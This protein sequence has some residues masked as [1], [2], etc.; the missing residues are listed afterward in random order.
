MGELSLCQE[1]IEGV[2][3]TVSP[4]ETDLTIIA[5]LSQPPI[6]AIG[7]TEKDG[8]TED[9]SDEVEEEIQDSLTQLLPEDEMGE[10]NPLQTPAALAPLTST[11]KI[12]TVYGDQIHQSD[13]T[14]LNG[15]VVD[16]KV[17]QAR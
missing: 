14:H 1:A 9:D 17:W 10:H 4:Q 12:A 3:A 16:D 7:A 13:G 11:Q 6:R 8:G 2:E 15:G 5:P